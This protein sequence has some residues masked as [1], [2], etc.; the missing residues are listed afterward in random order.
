MKREDLGGNMY[1]M[2]Y[3]CRDGHADVAF[4]VESCPACVERAR[5]LEVEAAAKAMLSF[6]DEDFPH[7][8]DGDSDASD[9]YRA[10]YRSLLAA[11]GLY[12]G[13]AGQG[14]AARQPARKCGYCDCGG[15]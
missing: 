13:N 11:L 15:D 8:P 12:G 14:N 5:K 3:R 2:P 4:G 6:V 1:M 10:A 9:G 7:G